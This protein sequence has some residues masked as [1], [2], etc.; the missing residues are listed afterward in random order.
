MG[1]WYKIKGKNIPIT[2]N[3]GKLKTGMGTYVDRI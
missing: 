2:E 3:H 1:L